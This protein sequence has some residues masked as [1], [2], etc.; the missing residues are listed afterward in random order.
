[1]RQLP[2]RLIWQARYFRALNDSPVLMTVEARERPVHQ[3]VEKRRQIALRCTELLCELDALGY[4][5]VLKFQVLEFQP[6]CFRSLA[7]LAIL[8]SF[9]PIVQVLAY[10]LERIE[11]SDELPEA[12]RVKADGSQ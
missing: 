11:L 3:L 7:V 10:D 5:P 1:M 4:D 2:P 6:S 9:V 8:P 12:G